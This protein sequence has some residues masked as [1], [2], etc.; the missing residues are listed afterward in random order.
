MFYNEIG[1]TYFLGMNIVYYAM[2]SNGEPVYF[3]II[4]IMHRVTGWY[5]RIE[6][7]ILYMVF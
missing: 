4:Y 6:T 2:L 3:Y 1:T 5:C 7:G